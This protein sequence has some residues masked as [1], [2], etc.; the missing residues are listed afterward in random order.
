MYITLNNPQKLW[1][2]NKNNGKFEEVE[3]FSKYMKDNC[4]E[5]IWRAETYNDKLYITD[6]L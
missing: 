5:Y 2:Y 1:K 6:G 4:I 3:G